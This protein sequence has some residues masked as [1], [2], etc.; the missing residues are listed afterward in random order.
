ME[1]CLAATRDGG[2]E[3]TGAPP[4]RWR[5]RQ[6]FTR[7]NI[8]PSISDALAEGC[9]CTNSTA[10]GRDFNL[11]IEGSIGDVA[12]FLPSQEICESKTGFA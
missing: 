5:K 11:T 6:P 9:L 7:V 2:I 12:P 4:M 3:G 1:A 10:L 8:D